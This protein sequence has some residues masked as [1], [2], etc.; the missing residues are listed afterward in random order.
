MG[1]DY[2]AILGLPKG[3]SDENELKKAYRKL[4]M[5]WHPDKNPDNNEEAEKKF[6][7]VSEAYEVLSDPQKRQIYDQYGEEGLKEGFPGAGGGGGG[8]GGGGGAR[9]FHPRAAE[10]LFA[11]LFGQAGMGG[12][13]FSFGGPGG[14]GSGGYEDMFFGPGMGG[15]GGMSS[16]GFSSRGSSGRYQQQPR[17]DP[18]LE[19]KL[20]CTLEDLYQG[21]TKKMKISRNKLGSKEEET[22][23]IDVKPGWKRG[24]KVT[25]KDKGDEHP[26]RLPADISF[27]VDEKPHTVYTRDGNDLVHS[28]NIHLRDAL[29][30]TTIQLRTLDGRILKV[31]VND[32]VTPNSVKVVAGEGMPVSK[33]PGK[34]GNLKV[35]FNVVFPKTLDEEQKELVRK[36]LPEV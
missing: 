25:F 5:K 24:T 10:D 14:G 22:L 18:T 28:A 7:E 2:Y 26:G 1:K 35:K 31:E 19:V 36:A 17:K 27:V 15:V 6:K 3:T 20:P 11:E 32:V 4:A 9:G 33:M 34:R 30:G 21:C 23:S 16:G 13:G 12:G 29:C 8:F